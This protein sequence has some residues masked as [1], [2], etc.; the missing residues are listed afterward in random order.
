[1][2]SEFDKPRLAA[3]TLAT[4]FT[5]LVG[6]ASLAIGQA[7]AI[8]TDGDGMVSFSE[9]LVLMPALSEEEFLALD[10]DA[11]GLLSA[12]EIGAAQDAGLV[13]AG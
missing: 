8:D 10:A 11:D 5:L 2:R 1:M 3:V 12:D 9:M 7:E 6:G 4:S 13:P